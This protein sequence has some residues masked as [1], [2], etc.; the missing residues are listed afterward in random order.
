MADIVII[1]GGVT[2][3]SAGIHILEAGEQH[4]VTICEAHARPGGNLTGW[5]R[6]GYQ[7]DNCIHWLNG[8]HPST[9]LYREWV[10]LGALGDG[11]KIRKRDSL[12]TCRVGQD[13]MTLWRDQARVEREMRWYASRNGRE[14]G[15]LFRAVRGLQGISGLDTGGGHRVIDTVDL[16]RYARMTT[17]ELADRFS[18]PLIRRFLTA[19]CGREFAAIAQLE[20][21]AQFCGGN[22]DLP[23]GGS[24][25][26]AERIADRFRSLGGILRLSTRVERVEY[27]RK[28]EG[29]DRHVRA[30]WAR[31]GAHSLHIPADLVILTCDPAVACPEILGVSLPPE[32]AQRYT[33]TAIAGHGRRFSAVQAAFS[34]PR[35]RIGFHGDLILPPPQGFS[36]AAEGTSLLLREFSHEPQFAPP[37]RTVIQIMAVCDEREARRI[38]SLPPAAYKDF[39]QEFVALCTPVL[40]E[41]CPRVRG[42]GDIQPLDVWTPAT[43]RRFTGSEVGSFMGFT[44]MPK[45]MVRDG[46]IRLGGKLK[47]CPAHGRIPGLDNILLTGQ[48][49][50]APGGL[51][52]AAGEGAQVA[53]AA[54]RLLQERGRI[55][56]EPAGAWQG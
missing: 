13:E 30:V 21:M 5:E 29:Y 33:N 37:G 26:M 52:I 49:L 44:M 35:V 56:V 41:V 6:K 3:L 27:E 42:A 1:G 43:Y 53:K 9:P 10:K 36:C 39:K 51:P 12:Y 17:G 46:L 54:A 18:H 32:L 40:E 50:H 38:L 7:I 22:A 55:R 2:G 20:I 14:I 47:L 45:D 15:R 23:A 4:R 8:T 31:Q 28:R 16:L 24:A 34:C 19:V 48:W 11:V 25:A